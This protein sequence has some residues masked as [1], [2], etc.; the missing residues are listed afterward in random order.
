MRERASERE[1]GGRVREGG[2]VNARAKKGFNSAGLPGLLVRNFA[3][4]EPVF[5]P[6]LSYG[7]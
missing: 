3:I 7:S 4:T 6:L 5:P 1:G 2:N